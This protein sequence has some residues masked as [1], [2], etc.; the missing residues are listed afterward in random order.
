MVRARWAAVVA[1]LTL[2]RSVVENVPVTVLDDAA[3]SPEAHELHDGTSDFL[4]VRQGH[5]PRRVLVLGPAGPSTNTL[6]P[7]PPP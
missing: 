5:R 3:D 2:V 7:S 6:A 1:G 4:Q